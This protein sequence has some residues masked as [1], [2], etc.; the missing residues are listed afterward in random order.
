MPNLD[1]YFPVSF[2]V[3]I[4]TIF[5]SLTLYVQI[6]PDNLPV[7]EG[8][9]CHAFVFSKVPH[10]RAIYP[11]RAVVQDPRPLQDVWQLVERYFVLEPGDL[12]AFFSPAAGEGHLFAFHHR[13]VRGK[14]VQQIHTWNNDGIVCR[15]VKVPGGVCGH[16]SLACL[17]F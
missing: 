16:F 11:Q 14:F 5:P 17:P 10:R 7:A 1:K 2:Q 6:S 15:V 9:F 13:L 8:I 4:K 12:D 3:V